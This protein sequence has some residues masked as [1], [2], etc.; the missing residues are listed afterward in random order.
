MESSSSARDDDDERT[1]R[2]YSP[3]EYPGADGAAMLV[4]VPENGVPADLLFLQ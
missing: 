4:R 1:L 3:V 2:E